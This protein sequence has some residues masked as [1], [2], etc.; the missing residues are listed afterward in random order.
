MLHIID[1]FHMGGAETWLL[2]IVRNRERTFPAMP[3][4]DFIAAGGEKAIFD[5]EILSHGCRI[6]YVKLD[7][8][9]ILS[10]IAEFRRIL[11]ENDYCAIHDHQDFLSGWHFLFGAGLLPKVCISHVHNPFEQLKTKYGVSLRRRLN[12]GLGRALS[13]VFATHILGTSAKLM[14]QHGLVASAYPSQKVGPL[15]CAFRI[16]RFSGSSRLKKRSLCLEMGWDPEST[17]IVLFAGRMDPRLDVHHPD[18]HKNSAFALEVLHAV[19]DPNVKMV[20]AGA[21]EYIREAFTGLIR[22]KAL[23]ERVH[24]LGVRTDMPDLMLAA[25]ALLFPSRMEGMGMVAVEAQAAGL[26]VL[27]STEVPGEVVVLEEM[28]RFRD[29]SDPFDAWASDL[30]RLIVSRGGG[31]TASDARW[32]RSGFNIDV[33]CKRLHDCYV[34]GRLDA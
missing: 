3:V 24:L 27:A 32:S 18:N 26:P 16:D 1:S 13:S 7:K 22:E 12:I 28:V 30:T 9:N 34:N 19:E 5:E 25:D 2:E 23:T 21:N 11:R 15:Y 14:G 10:F 6:F 29:L 33:C 8:R 31:D 4:F 20:M 17:R